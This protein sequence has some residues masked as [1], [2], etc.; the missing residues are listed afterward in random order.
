MDN[1]NLGRFNPW[2]TRIKFLSYLKQPLDNNE[3]TKID[4]NIDADHQFKLDSNKEE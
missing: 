3:K 4:Q 2:K 1:Q